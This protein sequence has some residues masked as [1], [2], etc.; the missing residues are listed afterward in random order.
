MDARGGDKAL[1]ARARARAR[2]IPPQRGHTP[3]ARTVEVLVAE[4]LDHAVDVLF[5]VRHRHR[6]EQVGLAQLAQ[7]HLARVGTVD[8]VENAVDDGLGVALLELGRLREEL[9]P[10]VARDEVVQHGQEVLIAHVGLASPQELERAGVHVQV[11]HL[12][13]E[14]V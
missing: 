9:K 5:V 6:L 12:R 14:A 4:V 2:R 11:R 13:L 10:R 8:A 3:H 1:R 7:R